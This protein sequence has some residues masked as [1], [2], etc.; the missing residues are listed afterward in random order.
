[1]LYELHEFKNA[2]MLP[3]HLWSEANG[4][5]I[6]MFSLENT[7]LG[8][9]YSASNEVVERTTRRYLK[10]EF[11]FSEITVKTGSRTQT[12]T[13][14]EAIVLDR[15]FC[16]LVHFKRSCNGHAFGANDPNVLIVAP[17]S[18]HFAT[19]L[20]DTVRELLPDHNVW[21]TDWK[22]ARLRK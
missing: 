21:I 19:L 9:L 13:I 4:L 18:G 15:P 5:F 17:L 6:N 14:E 8:R 2:A 3:A 1:M 20:R 16:N 11:G 22:D 7:S 12:C 10:P